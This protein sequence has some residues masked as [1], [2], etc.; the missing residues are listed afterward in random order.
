MSSEEA[1]GLPSYQMALRAP[2]TLVDSPSLIWPCL[3][4][5][6]IRFCQT[7]SV[8]GAREKSHVILGVKRFFFSFFHFQIL[9]LVSAHIKIILISPLGN[10]G[11]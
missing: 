9:F 8:S 2:F 6:H 5:S 10:A 1:S 3:A 7:R 11:R 4:D